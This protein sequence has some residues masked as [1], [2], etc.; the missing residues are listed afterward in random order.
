M[1]V[2]QRSS[3]R[4]GR[5]FSIRNYLVNVDWILLLATGALVTV[6][7]VMIYSATHA[8]ASIG[9]ATAYVSD[10]SF[11]LVLGLAALIALTFVDFSWF[12]G[13]GRYVYWANIGLL[14]LTLVVGAEHGTGARRWLTL[15]FFDI[16]TSELG[17]IFLILALA[18][19]LVEGVELRG[20]LRFVI[21]AV[22]YVALPAALIFLQPNLGTA[23]VFVAVMAAMLVVW[24]IRWSHV[25]ILFGGGLFAVTFVLRVL[26]TT[27]GIALLKPYQLQRLTVFLNPEQDTSGAAYQLAQSKI[28]VASGMFT[29]KGYMQGT[30][31]HLNFLPAHHTDFIFSV[32]GEEFGFFGAS[33]LLLLFAV[34]L[35]RA[36]RVAG[37]SKSLHGTLISA[38]VIGM[39]LFQVFVNVGMTLGIMPITGIPLPFVSFGSNSLLVFLAAVGLLESVHIHSRTALYGGRLKGDLHGQMAT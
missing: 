17:K 1:N 35:W 32:V 6:G 15:P 21:K 30:Q 5:G 4:P 10:Q 34:V 13:L 33:V 9:S 8:D 37:S 7:M 14:V 23:L 20:S 22:A 36:F 11:G 12:A 24:G 25:A 3:E 18:A 29:G 39:L 27:F 28:A 2:L 16:Q 19:F 38:G 31:T 26:P